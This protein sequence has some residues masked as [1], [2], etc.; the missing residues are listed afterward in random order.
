[1]LQK[2]TL[3]FALTSLL[4]LAAC[5]GKGGFDSGTSSNSAANNGSSAG[6]GAGTV[7]PGG[8]A[9]DAFQSLQYKGLISGGND[10]GTLAVDIDKTN[11]ALLLIMPL[12]MNSY[13]DSA[14]VQIPD[15]PGVKLITYKD[16]KGSSFIAVSVPLRYVLK[17][18]SFLNPA[19][20]P[21]GDPLPQIAGGELP[22]LGITIPGK[23]NVKFN[24]YLGLDTVCIYVSS[25]FDPYIGLTFP[26]KNGLTTIGFLSSV[27]AKANYDGGFFLSTQM[28]DEVAR[29]IDDHFH[30]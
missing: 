21:N 3:G 1:M 28:P 8:M 2:I 22:S 4:V 16:Q 27:P 10:N 29:I 9:P 23:N 30:F 20:L 14:E 6:E 15:L 17:G 11:G 26:I 7:P 25:P 12:Q 5:S 19:R 24:L 18:A 13:I